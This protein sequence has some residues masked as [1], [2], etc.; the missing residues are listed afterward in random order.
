MK[1]KDSGVG[2][3][4]DAMAAL[5]EVDLEGKRKVSGERKPREDE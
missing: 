2:L 4:G 3:D 5:L 1:S